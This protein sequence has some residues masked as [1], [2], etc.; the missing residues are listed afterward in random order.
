MKQKIT[1][2]ITAIYLSVCSVTAISGPQTNVTI[3]GQVLDTHTLAQL[4][5]Q[6]GYNIMSGNY[7]L[8]H[9]GCWIETNSGVSGCIDRVTTYSRYGSGERTS[10]G[11]WNHYSNAA[12]IGVGGTSDG[13]IYTTSGWSNC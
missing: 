6:L 8:G 2:L 3:N 10:D 4:E 9:D 13:C 11:S 5:Q 12:G 1:C 7:L